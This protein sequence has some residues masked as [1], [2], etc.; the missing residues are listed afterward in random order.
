MMICLIYMTVD[1]LPTGHES[2]QISP[3]SKDEAVLTARRNSPTD[4]QLFF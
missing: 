1:V 3:P 4:G 2:T